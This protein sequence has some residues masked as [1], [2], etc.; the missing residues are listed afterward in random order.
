MSTFLGQNAPSNTPP[1][2][3]ER[4]SLPSELP[5]LPIRN[6]VIFPGISMPLVVGRTR[7]I[8]AV[9]E[10]ERQQQLLLIVAQKT[11]TTGDPEPE[12]L[13]R[14]G[15]LC[16]LESSSPSETGGRQIMVTGIAR[17]RVLDYF[18][19]IDGSLRARGEWVADYHG[20][21]TPGPE[22]GPAET[23]RPE[24]LF[25]SLKVMA[26]EVL[27]LM[28]GATEALVRLI[29]KI[30][31]PTYLTHVAAAYLNLN[32]TQKQELL[33]DPDLTRR[34]EK[35]IDLMAK[36]RDV[37]GVQ[38]EIR[39][40]MSERLNKAQ[41]EALLREQLR[42][43]RSEL[44]EENGEEISDEM[45]EKIRKARLPAEPAKQAEEEL[46]RL[47]QLPPASAEYHV[48]RTYLEWLAAMPWHTFTADNLDLDRARQVLDQDHSG[49]E[50]VKRR[51][52]QF[53]AVAK[54][55]NDLSGPIL[56]LV[57]PPGVGKTS[58]GQSI[59]RTMERKFIRTSLGGVRDEAEIRG[60][61]RT[62]VGAMP[63]RI[64]QSIKRAQ[65]KNPVMM[66]DEIDKLRADFQGDPS[67]ALL[68]VLDPEQNQ[69][70]VDH[71]L[72]VP[73]DLSKVFFICTANVVDTIPPPLRDRM[74]IIELSGYTNHEKLAIARTHLLRKQLQA[75]GLHSSQV[76]VSDETLSRMI[77]DY[78]R[79]AGV[80]EL[81]RKLA[82]LLRAC[83]E[84]WVKERPT[85]PLQ[86]QPEHL[87]ELLGPARYFQE[88]AGRSLRPG[89]ATGLAWTPNGGDILFIE[90]TR[91]PGKGN[92]V[93]TGQLGDVMKE[94]A[95]IALSLARSTLGSIPF[96]FSQWD[97]HIHVPA[98]GIPKDGPSAGVTLVS[99]LVSLIR[100][101]SIDPELGMTGEITLRG[102]VLPVG[103]IK[104]KVLAAHRAG[105][106]RILSAIRIDFVDTVEQV[107]SRAL[108][109]TAIQQEPSRPEVA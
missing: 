26:E 31:D 55:K 9:E 34:M 85:Q 93:L 98:G 22:I 43:I 92:L 53:L 65:S 58:L 76:Q 99:S 30:D 21:K 57:G 88:I 11:I 27:E 4:Q 41:R 70:F 52:L 83:A 73:Y 69:T 80:R 37:L 42:T 19:A 15:T 91:M 36:E 94:S 13:Y 89:I 8:L 67:A 95:Q 29:H 16:K 68:E 108:M 40:K 59:A 64:I 56:C 32:L 49:L 17:Y 84:K 77:T 10:S 103:G 90:S 45:A 66:L 38:R 48:V 54:L 50:S 104:E 51:I 39:E 107:V 101:Q 102:V 25:Q 1:P 86:I 81:Q 12:D 28:P 2:S 75:H 7:S 5:V 14:T 96:D 20:P 18:R 3:D 35:I 23:K 74:E 60:H 24:E 44:G 78:T 100:N 105:L 33:E 63:G 46:K 62:Y 106:K 72:D 109:P 79:E 61:R 47:R 82:A 71:Y 6:T 87:T 97:L